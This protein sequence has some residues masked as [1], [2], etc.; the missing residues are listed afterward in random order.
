MLSVYILLI[1]G[2]SHTCCQPASFSPGKYF[3]NLTAN[4]FPDDTHCEEDQFTSPQPPDAR[5]ASEKVKAV[6]IQEDEDAQSFRK[7]HL[8][9]KFLI[10]SIFTH[11]TWHT[12]IYPEPAL[13]L[14]RHFSHASPDKYIV[15]RVIRI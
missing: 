2:Y 14:C 13:P 1:G 8:Y 3:L 9:C 15:Q 7:Q 12:A 11:L 6:E 10:T 5:E 4:E